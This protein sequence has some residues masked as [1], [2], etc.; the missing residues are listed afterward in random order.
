MN[1][2]YISLLVA[3]V[4]CS[5]TAQTWEPV[6]PVMNNFR[7]DHTFG[8]SIN[9][10]GYLVTGYDHVKGF[11]NDFYSYDAD[12]DAWSVKDPFPGV[13]RG[14]A[15]GDIYENK[16]YLGFGS[17]PNGGLNDLWVYDPETD[18]W[19]ELA[20]CP[21]VQRNHP[22]MIAVNGFIYVGLGS[23]NNGNL[24]D[25]WAY[26]IEEDSWSQKTDF[27]DEARHHPY[28]FKIGEYVY[29]GF[30]H[31]SGFISNEWYRYDPKND[32][33]MQVAS[34]P[35][36]GR[37][38]GAQFSYGGYGYVLSGD[39]SDHAYMQT[40]EFWRYDP[41]NDSWTSLPPHPEESRWAPA[42]F[43]IKDHVYIINGWNDPD[44]FLDEVYKFNLNPNQEPLITLNAP[45]LNNIEY[46]NNKD[47]YCNPYWEGEMEIRTDISFESDIEYTFSIDPSSTAI[48]GIDFVIPNKNGILEQGELTKNIVFHVFDDGLQVGN[49]K[50]IIILTANNQVETNQIDIYDNDAN[51]QVPFAQLDKAISG[52][53]IQNEE[54]FIHAQDSL[55]LSIASVTENQDNCFSVSLVNNS[56][57]LIPDEEVIRLDRVYSINEDNNQSF[58]GTIS[59]AYPTA[60][61]LDWTDT[62]LTGLYTDIPIIQGVSPGWKLTDIESVVSIDDITYVDLSFQGNG[63]YAIGINNSTSVSDINQQLE[64]DHIRYYDILG[65][66]VLTPEYKTSMTTLHFK[67]YFQHG[68]IVK[69][70]PVFR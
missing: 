55:L 45:N 52:K 8:F 14:F 34:L 49:K 25:W 60:T 17:S 11:T 51:F 40:G 64:Y 3:F 66:E 16:A 23:G 2:Y 56:L 62:H 63:N 33:W 30:G 57:D 41:E 69:S 5:L 24:K 27:P 42:S 7:S 59:F 6:S 37:V 65:R 20:S 48:E 1:Q 21:C 43:I 15:I 28:Q 4:C 31:G 22:A 18:N 54:V 35:S 38:A 9:D 46:K 13:A 47:L 50:I 61:S 39:G 70:E 29:T 19:T 32:T 44:G 10:V 67:I 26:N 58:E 53:A 68:R 36:E 12:T